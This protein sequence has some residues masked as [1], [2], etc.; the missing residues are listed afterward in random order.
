MRRP[1]KRKPHTDEE[2]ARQFDKQLWRDST[3]NQVDPLMGESSGAYIALFVVGAI[4]IIVVAAVLAV[5]SVQDEPTVMGEEM[6]LYDEQSGI[7]YI[8][9]P[10]GPRPA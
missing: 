3:G 6:R 9:T 10:V 4:L 1:H 7:E 5:S 2:R 8:V